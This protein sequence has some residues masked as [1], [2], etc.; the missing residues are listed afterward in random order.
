MRY[1]V[2]SDI[3]AN[4]EAL[5]KCLGVAKGKHDRVLC[6]G[7]LVGYG[8]DPNAAMER[9]RELAN[10][11]I[12]GNHDKACAGITDA[13]DFNALARASALWTRNELTP[14]NS[15]FL[16]SLPAGPVLLDGF[17]LV[18]GSPADE[19]EYIAGPVQ[20][21]PAL[22]SLTLQTVFFGHT[23]H[24]GGFMLTRQGHFQSIRDSILR[25]GPGSSDNDQRRVVLPLEDGFRYLINPG[26]V[27]QPRDGD[28]R[29]AFAIFD[30]SKRKVEYYRTPYDLSK[31]QEKMQKAGLPEPLI[32][33]L[34]IGR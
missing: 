4:L 19:D 18:H 27:G 31:T 5:E 8:P 30:E 9:T 3:H 2:L 15:A 29:A 14:Q 16:R 7:D 20:A 12:R 1:L 25:Q 24:Q 13:E 33:R 34:A 26:S 11:V 23:H 22:R 10:T 32:L 6:L 17:E 28:W 21:L